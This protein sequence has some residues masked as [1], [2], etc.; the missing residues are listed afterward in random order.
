LSAAQLFIFFSRLSTAAR[1]S[2]SGLWFGGAGLTAP[3]GQLFAR[4]PLLPV[5]LLLVLGMNK[6]L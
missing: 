6:S 4:E 2:I 5:K 3:D 1:R